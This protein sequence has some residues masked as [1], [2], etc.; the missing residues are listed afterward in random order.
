[1]RNNLHLN[2]AKTLFLATGDAFRVYKDG[3][4]QRTQYNIYAI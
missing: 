4:F 2:Y 3:I 1:M